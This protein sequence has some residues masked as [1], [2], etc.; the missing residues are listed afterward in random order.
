MYFP[1]L[2]CVGYNI[3][4]DFTFLCFDPDRKNNEKPNSWNKRHDISNR[5]ILFIYLEN[6]TEGNCSFWIFAD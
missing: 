1:M 3:K 4:Q 6:E 5:T 2:I